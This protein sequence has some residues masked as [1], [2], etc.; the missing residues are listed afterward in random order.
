[1]S[2]FDRDLLERALAYVGRPPTLTPFEAPPADL[3]VRVALAL[4][5]RFEGFSAH[6]YLC[7]AGKPTI[8]LGA[9]YYADGRPVRLTDP[10]ISIDAARRLQVLTIQRVY[11]PAVLRLCPGVRDPYLLAA[12][13]DF[14]FNLGA[15]NLAASTLRRRVNAGDL[16]A[17]YSEFMR[18]VRAAG[19]VLRG[20]VLRRQAEVHVARTRTYP[21]EGATS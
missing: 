6:P 19:R 14:C 16:D 5:E 3:A 8:G 18:W 10:P 13:I 4:G 15:G 7:P 1:M 17:A 21:L 20:L 11:L 9:T 12:L 2:R